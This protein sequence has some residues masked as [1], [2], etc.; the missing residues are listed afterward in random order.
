MHLAACPLSQRALRF[1]AQDRQCGSRT[2]QGPRWDFPFI[3][4]LTGQPCGSRGQF[5]GATKRLA[6]QT[7]P[8]QLRY[9]ARFDWLII[10]EF[11]F[12]KIE[13]SEA[14]QAASLLFKIIDGRKRR[15]TTVVTNI[16]FDAWGPYLGDPPLA[17]GMLDGSGGRR[18][19][20]YQD[21]RQ[22]LPCLPCQHQ[23]DAG[24]QVRTTSPGNIIALLQLQKPIGRQS[25]PQL[26]QAAILAYF[27]T[28][29][30][31]PVSPARQ[32]GRHT[33]CVTGP[34]RVSGGTR[35]R[36]SDAAGRCLSCSAPDTTSKGGRSRTLCVRVG[37]A[38]LSQEHTLVKRKGDRIPR[39]AP[40]GV[41][42]A[43]VPLTAGCSTC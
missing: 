25:S 16:D 12:D 34:L 19:D 23:E 3:T 33:R 41:E 1:D 20:H 2:H 37:A 13:R 39:T 21:Q 15:S 31:R 7:L 22:V 32:A 29:I 36:V 24:T 6:D 27:L 40:A 38:L 10:D 26:F 11:A 8:K 14:P 28:A 35:T 42:P 9:Y 5:Q 4:P 18:G 17:M 30:N 43:T